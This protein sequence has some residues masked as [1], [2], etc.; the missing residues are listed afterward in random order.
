MC[1]LLHE[2]DPG[3]CL[4]ACLHSS[5]IRTCALYPCAGCLPSLNVSLGRSRKR[6]SVSEN[7][8]DISTAGI[9]HGA[10]EWTVFIALDRHG[11]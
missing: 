10:Q 9:M 2:H 8:S 11:G 7:G 5:L 3:V 1:H 4:L 6:I